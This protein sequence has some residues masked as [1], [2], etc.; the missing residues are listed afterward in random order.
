MKATRGISRRKHTHCPRRGR[1]RGLG[2]PHLLP[3]AL[4]CP[5]RQSGSSGRAS[6]LSP[7]GPRLSFREAWAWQVALP[8]PPR[9]SPLSLPRRRVTLSVVGCHCGTRGRSGAGRAPSDHVTGAPPW[10]VRH[11]VSAGGG[12][13]AL[14]PAGD[15]S[16]Q[17]SSCGRGIKGPER[18]NA[19]T[20]GKLPSPPGSPHQR[21]AP[22]PASQVPG[23]KHNR[24]IEG[25]RLPQTGFQA[26]RCVLGTVQ[27][28][29]ALAGFLMARHLMVWGLSTALRAPT[30]RPSAG[31]VLLRAVG[32]RHRSDHIRVFVWSVPLQLGPARGVNYLASPRRP[33]PVLLLMEKPGLG[34]GSGFGPGR[35]G[36]RDGAVSLGDSPN[37]AHPPHPL[38]ILESQHQGGQEGERRRRKAG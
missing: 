30:D 29:T 14:A 18:V 1:A 38:G 37:S 15:G 25:S 27:E 32:Q 5:G 2:S 11:R 22:L 9:P 24:A 19:V 12:L 16:L 28:R 20:R 23:S 26:E 7:V 10:F 6:P 8:G 21:S 3:A 13:R 31:G 4:R 33:I 34:K 35:S 17:P 36:G